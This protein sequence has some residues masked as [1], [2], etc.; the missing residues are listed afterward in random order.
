MVDLVDPH[1]LHLADALP[2]LQG[3]AAYAETHAKAYRRIESVAE[4]KGKLR[5]LDLT[6]REVRKAI[7]IAKDATSLFGGALAVDY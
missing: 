7:S 4:V 6:S 3:L 1:G 5:A 2:K